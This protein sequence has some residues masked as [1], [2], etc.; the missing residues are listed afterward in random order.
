MLRLLLRRMSHPKDISDE[1]LYTMARHE[2]ICN[3]IHLPAQSGNTRVLKAMNRT[4]TRE[5]YLDKVRKIREII[6]GCGISCDIIAG[7]CTETEE[8]HQDTLSLMELS[9]FDFS[10]MYKY[11]ERP[12]TLAQKKMTDDV[13]EEV[14]SRRL[15]EIIALQN[16]LSLENNTQYIGTVVRVL[17]DGLSKKSDQ[18]LSGRNDQNIKVVFPRENYNIGD[19]VDVLVERVTTTT[20]IGKAV[21]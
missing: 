2:N 1:V 7:F 12:G 19:Y 17:A 16:R 6:P 15:T 11:S 9:R 20:L 13:P 21:R 10:Y 3:Y 14:K 8:E 4:Y 18:D 5:W